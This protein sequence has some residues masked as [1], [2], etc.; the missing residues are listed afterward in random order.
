MKPVTYLFMFAGFLEYYGLD[1]VEVGA[2]AFIKVHTSRGMHQNG[3]MHNIS[4]T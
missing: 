1:I 3:V 4:S 2:K